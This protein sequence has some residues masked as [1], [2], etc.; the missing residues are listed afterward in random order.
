MDLIAYIL[1]YYSPN[2]WSSI[3]SWGRLLTQLSACTPIFPATILPHPRAFNLMFIFNCFVLFTIYTQCFMD[4][5]RV[6]NTSSGIFFGLYFYPAKQ[7]PN[8]K[9]SARTKKGSFFRTTQPP[10]CPCLLSR[11]SKSIL[12]TRKEV[13]DRIRSK[14]P[15]RIPVRESLGQQYRRVYRYFGLFSGYCGESAKE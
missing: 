15:E 1:H 5:I 8:T 12:S 9:D 3:H 14:Y 2:G 10:P 13:A 7:F 11:S 6:K 4:S